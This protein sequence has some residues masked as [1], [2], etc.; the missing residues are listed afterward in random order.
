MK[1]IKR[2]NLKNMINEG[3]REG[4][5]VE[6]IRNKINTSNLFNEE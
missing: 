1:Q 2:P 4:L 5:T 3:I 6:E